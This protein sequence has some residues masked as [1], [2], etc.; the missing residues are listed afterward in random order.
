[1]D[2][3]SI[4]IK[5]IETLLNR[6]LNKRYLDPD[7]NKNVINSII[8]ISD[9]NNEDD[10]VEKIYQDHFANKE[11]VFDC[12]VSRIRNYLIIEYKEGVWYERY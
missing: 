8:N 2:I 4:D 9:F 10:I 1:M 6:D 12:E 5:K 3:K 11:K 7:Y